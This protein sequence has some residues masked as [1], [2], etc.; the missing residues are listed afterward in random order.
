M[1][2]GYLVDRARVGHLHYF[3][4][5]SALATLRDCGYEVIQWEFANVVRHQLKTHFSVKGLV[6]AFPRLA[7][8]KLSQS[9]A[10]NLLGGASLN[11][12][13]KTRSK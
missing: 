6:A 3:S 1:R 12:L 10:V 7:L 5:A 4:K 13:C 8:Y 11:V 2:G 9:F